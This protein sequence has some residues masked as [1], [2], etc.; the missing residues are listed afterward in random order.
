[1]QT[2]TPAMA[3]RERV[4]GL[5]C[6]C[7]KHVRVMT[8][9]CATVTL[10]MRLPRPIE[11]YHQLIYF[12]I[13]SLLTNKTK[14]MLILSCSKMIIVLASAQRLNTQINNRH[15]IVKSRPRSGVSSTT[16]LTQFFYHNSVYALCP[17]HTYSSTH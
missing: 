3:N 4:C 2:H 12:F 6:A 8:T 13:S 11:S 10:A 5:M 9:L 1:M 15:G 14:V 16:H 17:Q 7:V